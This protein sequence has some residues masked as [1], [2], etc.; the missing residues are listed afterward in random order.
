[1]DH[2]P[3]F[4]NVKGRRTLVVGGGTL[5]ARKA[6]LLVR[7]GA[8]ITVLADPSRLIWDGLTLV[9]P[10]VSVGALLVNTSSIS[11]SSVL[12]A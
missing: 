4:L 11:S 8:E 2:L 10:G 5:A 7:A 1:M 3:I 12:S 6:D 9:V